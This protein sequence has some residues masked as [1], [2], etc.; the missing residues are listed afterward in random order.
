MPGSFRTEDLLAPIAAYPVVKSE[1]RK[2]H[3]SK[4]DYHRKMAEVFRRAGY[5][6]A[7]ALHNAAATAHQIVA[8]NGE[9]DS[10]VDSDDIEAANAASDAAEGAGASAST[11]YAD[12]GSEGS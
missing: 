9:E 3:A 2:H 12:S 1:Q 8:D 10:S 7:Y 5:P 11:G 4:A 6:V